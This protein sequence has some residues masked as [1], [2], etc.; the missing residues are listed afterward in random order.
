MGAAAS[1]A[2]EGAATPPTIIQKK[3]HIPGPTELDIKPG[4][5]SAVY[6]N[7]GIVFHVTFNGDW[8][9]SGYQEFR[10]VAY[11]IRSMTPGY[12]DIQNSYII[13]TRRP[14]NDPIEV[15][16]HAEFYVTNKDSYK[17]KKLHKFKVWQGPQSQLLKKNPTQRLKTI[18]EIKLRLVDFY[19]LRQRILQQGM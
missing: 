17:N 1:T 8:D 7:H 9:G 18:D 19:K 2:P 13:Q 16:I 11:C 3:N 4:P 6:D 14:N 12:D 15:T 10:T 5:S